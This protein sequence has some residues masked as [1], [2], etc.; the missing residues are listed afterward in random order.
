M[1]WRAAPLVGKRNRPA[2]AAAAV[3]VLGVVAV[4]VYSCPS[5]LDAE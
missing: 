3:V 5:A 2:A 4:V 1:S